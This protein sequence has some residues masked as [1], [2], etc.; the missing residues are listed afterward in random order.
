[1]LGSYITGRVMDRDFQHTAE[2]YR[3]KHQLPESFKMDKSKLDDFPFERA[4]MRNIWLVVAVFF[5]SVAAYGWSIGVPIAVPLVLQFLSKSITPAPLLS[6]KTPPP[7]RMR[8]FSNTTRLL[9][10]Q[11]P[12]QRQPS[13][14]STPS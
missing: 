9:L 7:Y 11:S 2:A 1:M 3:R 5:A 13:S 12:T 10:H 6:T 8:Q 14:T 4:R